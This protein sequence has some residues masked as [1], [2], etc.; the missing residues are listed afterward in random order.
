M[1]LSVPNVQS[2]KSQ[3]LSP[4]RRTNNLQQRMFAIDLPLLYHTYTVFQIRSR[5]HIICLGAQE[6]IEFSV[7]LL[8]N[9]MSVTFSGLS[10]KPNESYVRFPP[11]QSLAW[12]IKI[13]THTHKKKCMQWSYWL[14]EL[15]LASKGCSYYITA[16]VT[17][18]SC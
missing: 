7:T 5:M 8:T 16:K 11:P 14:C 17:S 15:K 4:R 6:R 9:G 1:T 13:H 18:T 12:N 2:R 3:S 10:P